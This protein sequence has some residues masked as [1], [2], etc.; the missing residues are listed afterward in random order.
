[1]SRLFF[2]LTS[3][4]KHPCAYACERMGVRGGGAG[5]DVVWIKW[6]LLWLISRDQAW[7][8]KRQFLLEQP[9]ITH[10]VGFPRQPVVLFWQHT[11]P[12]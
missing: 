12:W 1:M 2:F 9:G 10:L 5:G 8:M 6:C 11:A 4:C 7:L 3:L